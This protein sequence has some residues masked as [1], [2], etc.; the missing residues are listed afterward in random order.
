MLC[1]C[2]HINEIAGEIDV[3]SEFVIGRHLVVLA[4]GVDDGENAFSVGP[5]TPKVGG[6]NDL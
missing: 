6:I 3:E 5:G 4:E 2:N 1:V